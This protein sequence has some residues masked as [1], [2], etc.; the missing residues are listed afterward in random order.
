MFSIALVV[1]FGFALLL[2]LGA[3]IGM[4]LV[5]HMEKR[6]GA[7]AVPPPVRGPSTSSDVTLYLRADAD[8]TSLFGSHELGARQGLLDAEAL[9]TVCEALAAHV[10]ALRDAAV[11]YAAPTFY[12]PYDDGRGGPYFRLRVRSRRPLRTVGLPIAR[13]ALH[14]SLLEMSAL[15]QGELIA[16]HLEAVAP[17]RDRALPKL[18]ALV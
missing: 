7:S 16:A 9:R 10:D 17:R 18:E 6:R 3:A 11:V 13:D 12:A 8:P 5:A 4:L 15:E 14:E 2:T 1:I